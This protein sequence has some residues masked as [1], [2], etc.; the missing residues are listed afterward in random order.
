M[1]GEPADVIDR[2]T[3]NDETHPPT[4]RPLHDG[5]TGALRPGG[6]KRLSPQHKT[7]NVIRHGLVMTSSPCAHPSRGTNGRLVPSSYGSPLGRQTWTSPVWGSSSM[8]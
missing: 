6:D 1:R 7:V 8:R 3:G 5:R 2:A 4:L